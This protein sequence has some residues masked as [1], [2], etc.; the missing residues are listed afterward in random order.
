M[1]EKYIWQNLMSQLMLDHIRQAA[2]ILWSP[3]HT[4]I[5]IYSYETKCTIHI[6]LRVLRSCKFD[7]CLISFSLILWQ[8][9]QRN[10]T[11][12][13]RRNI[14]WSTIKNVCFD[15]LEWKFTAAINCQKSINFNPTTNDKK[16]IN[17]V[18][19]DCLSPWGFGVWFFSTRVC[20]DG[21]WFK[22]EI[23]C[24]YCD[25]QCLK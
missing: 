6:P 18:A 15:S 9:Q 3:N 14:R 25:P 22:Y 8:S 17:S 21:Q 7:R 11:N 4:C 13:S 1:D 2:D 20:A 23:Y 24:D 16:I 10:Q 5:F 19:T 12:L